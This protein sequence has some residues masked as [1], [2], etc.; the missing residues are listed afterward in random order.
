[1]NTIEI[2]DL[3]KNYTSGGRKIQALGE[4]IWKLVRVCSG[5]L[6]PMAPEK[7]H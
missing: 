3:V 2:H 4:S 6:D 1:M 7:Q 5:C